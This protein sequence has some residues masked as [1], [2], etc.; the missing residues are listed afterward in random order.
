MRAGYKPLPGTD[1][2]YGQPELSDGKPRLK[3]ASGE[4]ATDETSLLT[5]S[6][7]FSVKTSGEKLLELDHLAPKVTHKSGADFFIT[8]ARDVLLKKLISDFEPISK[9]VAV[10]IVGSTKA[11]YY[12]KDNKSEFNKLAEKYLK[13]G[14]ER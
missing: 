13:R 3:P 11:N 5:R 9:K 12:A 8:E 1:E 2:V 14:F 10:E 4:R 6:T 7:E